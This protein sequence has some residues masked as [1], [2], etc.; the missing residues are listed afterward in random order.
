MRVLIH[1][2]YM[3]QNVLFSLF[4][5]QRI[6]FFLSLKWPLL[7]KSL[8]SSKCTT[9]MQTLKVHK[10]V[11]TDNDYTMTST[12]WGCFPRHILSWERSWHCW[13]NVFRQS[14]HWNLFLSCT[15]IMCLLKSEFVV[16]VLWQKWQWWPCPMCSPSWRVLPQAVSSI[17]PQM[18]HGYV[19]WLSE[20]SF[21]ALEA[22]EKSSEST[23][24]LL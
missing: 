15:P 6:I 12:Y 8:F 18:R 19:A 14:A 9:R 10:S 23:K 24:L 5:L 1:M 20:W 13:V 17:L 3:E 7:P 4:F 21:P 16:K 2:I 22:E 11:F